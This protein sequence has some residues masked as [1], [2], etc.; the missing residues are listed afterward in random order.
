M[1]AKRDSGPVVV[2][3]APVATRQIQRVVESV[4]TLFPYDEVII[5]AEVDGPVREVS[6]DLGDTVKEGQVLARISDEEQRYLVAQ[7]EAQL[8]Q[9]LERLGLKN[10]NDKVADIRQTPEVR[11]AQADLFDAEQRYK[12][13]R[14]LVDQNI[15]SRQ[16]LDAAGARY[17]A[18]QAEY[19]A[20]LN[21]TRNLIQEVERF[22]AVLELQRKKL[23][24]T[25]VRAPFNASV[26]ER[27]VTVGQFVR[28]NTPLFTLV[29]TDPIRLRVEIPERMAPWVKEGQLADVTVEAFPNRVFRGKIWRISPTVDESKRTFIVEALIQ[30]PSGELKPGSYAKASVKTSKFEEIRL[31]PF[32]AVNYVLGSYKAYVVKDG[33]VEARDV[34]LGDRFGPDVE[35]D[36][37][38]RDGEV[39]AVTQVQRLDSGSKVRVAEG[40]AKDSGPT[41]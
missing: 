14:E 11:R 10:E 15:G 40:P 17:K 12:R 26:K 18:A 41:E 38:L 25:V 2:R 8:R 13:V 23:R 34:K 9:S 28:A 24:D 16:D 36:D 7:N 33:T 19:D 21:Q 30:N 6:A 22:K 3:V 5:S 35:V 32:S 39:V 31:V 27:Q 1:E 29:K 4:G 20:T 37:G